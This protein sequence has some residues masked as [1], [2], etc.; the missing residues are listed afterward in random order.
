MKNIVPISSGLNRLYPGMNADAA[1]RRLE[2]ALRG[3]SQTFGDT[4]PRLFSAPGRTEVCGNHTDHQNGLVLAAAVDLDDVAAAA[5]NNEYIVRIFSDK[6]S[7]VIVK[8]D[9]T[10]PREDEEFT[11]AVR[12]TYDCERRVALLGNAP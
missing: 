9:D 7:P 3:F 1:L 11:S 5:L 8:L 2:P 4:K 12:I 6:Y 10:S